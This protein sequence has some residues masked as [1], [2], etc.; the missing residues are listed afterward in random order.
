MM[1]EGRLLSKAWVVITIDALYSAAQGLCS[2]F[3]TVYLWVNSQDF[4]TICRFHIALYAITPIAFLLAGWYAQARDRL[5][6]LRIGIILH[7]VLYGIL[8]YLREDSPAWSAWIG[9][10][11][12]ITWGIYYAG[13]NT[14]TFDVTSVGRREYFFGLV[15]AIAGGVG[16]ISP[17]LSGVIIRFVPGATTGYHVIFAM[18]LGI[19]VLS[20]IVSFL[21]PPDKGPR[22]YRITRAL[23]PGKDQRD[24]QIVMLASASLAGSFNIF[25]FVL[26]LLMYLHTSDELSVGG[27]ASFQALA[28]VVTAFFVGRVAVP[29]NR[30]T[31][32]FWGVA[33]LVAAGGLMAFPISITTLFLFGLLRCISGPMFGIPHSGLRLD[34]INHCATDPSE[35]IEYI[36][37]WEVPLAIGRVIMMTVLILLYNVLSQSELGIRIVL[38]LLCAVRIITYQLVIRTSPLRGG[39]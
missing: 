15:Q 14:L 22:P 19:Y 25:P 37:A 31:F 27:Y 6:M 1:Q 32:M 35:R 30:R 38:F 23:F 2:V 17:L 33:T 7:A 11:Q 18:A 10:F 24:W 21:L 28:A 12:G 3:V 36:A 9:G 8:L 29:G 16:L 20:F 4:N 13:L 39:R 26:G 5:H 34:V